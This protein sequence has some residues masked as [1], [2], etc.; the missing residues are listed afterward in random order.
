MRDDLKKLMSAYSRRGVNDWK[1]EAAGGLRVAASGCLPNAIVEYDWEIGRVIDGRPQ[2]RKFIPMP[3]HGYKKKGFE[4]CFFLPK[5]VRGELKSLTLFILVNRA[6]RDCLA[7]RFEGSSHGPH[8]YSHVQLTSKLSKSGLMMPAQIVVEK[9]C[10]PEWL[11]V[12]YPAFPIPAT[13]WTE[14]FLAMA[15]AVHGR[16]GGIDI[17][18]QEVLQEAQSTHCAHRYGAMLEERLFKL[19]LDADS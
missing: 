3:R 15:T 16:Y 12:S 6:R 5:R 19:S 7:F 11:P 17:L 4:W 14:M 10:L 8:G 18:L 9:P 1:N 2:E 13:N